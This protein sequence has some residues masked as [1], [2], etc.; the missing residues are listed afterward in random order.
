V[1]AG[2][3]FG[4][5]AGWS[6]GHARVLLAVTAVA[7]AAAA[8]GTSRLGT[9]AG[10]DTLVDRDSQTLQA[11]EHFRR[12]FGDD[13]VVVLVKGD[14]RKLVLTSNLG[15]LLRLEGCLSG[16]V[17]KGAKPLPGACS[18]IARLHPAK[19]VYGPATFLNQAVLGIETALSGQIK[20]TQAQELSVARTAAR[21]AAE[22]G[23][24]A[25]EQ[26]QAAKAAAAGVGQRFE[27]RLLRVAAQYGITRLPRIDD[28]LFVSQ[29]VFDNRQA[30]GTPKGRFAY[31]FPNRDSALISI[32]LRPDLS[33]S[34]R[35]RA[36]QLIR[37]A[38]YDTTP[39]KACKKKPCFALD[40][41]RYVI[42]GAPVVID[43]VA[44]KLRSALLVL[45]AAAVVVMAATLAIVFRSRLRLLPLALA[46][47]A[48][49]ITFGL[50]GLVGGSL[51]IAAIAVLPILIGLAVD[52]AIQLQARF[53]EAQAGGAAGAEAARIAAV[54]AAPVV[55]TAC[56][57]SAAGFCVLL[58]SPVPMVRDFGLMLVGGVA[59]A[60][61]L[62]LTAGFAALALRE[63]RAPGRR[64]EAAVR[65]P[66]SGAAEKLAAR[67]ARLGRPLASLRGAIARRIESFG[68]QALAA[69]IQSP[70]RVLAAAAALAICGW[71]VA[72][73]VPIQSDFTKLVPQ[74]LREV[75]DLR[76]LQ[77]A[78][79]V[80]GELDV[81]VQ[82]PD[83]T[84]PRLI[85]WM[86]GF[87]QRVLEEHG[88]RGSFASCRKAEI[89]PGT[90]PTDF[91]ANPGQHLSR[92]R[93]RAL[94]DAIPA[95]D[96]QAVLTSNPRSGEL[97]HTANIS[98]GIRTMPL[99][100]QQQLIEEIRGDIDPPGAGNGPP[101]GTEVRLAG[102]PVLAA[103][104]NSSL[105]SSRY[106][107]TLAGL[108][109]VALVLL[110]V[111]RSLA[112][113]LVPLIP[114]VLATGWASLVLFA[115]HTK[116]NPMSA[117]L[118][119]LVIAIATEFSV[120]LASR[121][122]EERGG[123]HSVGEALRRSY[124][125]T[126]A[127]VLASGLTAIA[128]FAT[129]IVTAIPG[130]GDYDFPM[131]RDFGFVT[132]VDL[133]V[134]LLGVLLVLPAVLVWAE[135]G[136]ELGGLSLPRRLAASRQ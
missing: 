121:Y 19:V 11:T 36:L 96:R 100:Q 17:P 119:A 35:H 87:K 54:R 70:A 49:A 58:L 20:R 26:R 94:Y 128:G 73:R 48:T 6:V 41:G 99:N 50:T 91:F 40:G 107:L 10:T 46:L 123:G 129:L 134:A 3:I 101:V 14:L 133:G 38:V 45:F 37:E 71:L 9:D 27:A 23:L 30:P 131:L 124:S 7:A 12:L 34:E 80:S 112:R 28:P 75:R 132:V 5:I 47:A 103:S 113:A 24:S 89:C 130:L 78:T 97:G 4:R 53:D 61:A 126:G 104:S 110:A 63:E 57:A 33:E 74:H 120:I 13:A 108:I 115:S 102:L 52:Y 32:R 56:L 117:T 43:G 44:G 105:A 135:A 69:S 29:V 39:R 84:D 62:A 114:I 118:G 136:F 122:R 42:S 2:E 65:A 21:A 64:K 60:F 16:N 59:I 51:T 81:T 25:A 18:E 68:T 93:I 106:W 67:A 88:F 22:Q 79:G 83:L 15:K 66:R 86:S 55:G 77:Q 8:F 127:A 1:S 82:A 98:F 109:G 90:S 116:L 85:E 92:A 125:R 76:E 111:Y 72:P 31:L 95:Y